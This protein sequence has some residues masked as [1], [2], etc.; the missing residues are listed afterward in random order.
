MVCTADGVV[1]TASK[2]GAVRYWSLDTGAALLCFE[3]FPLRV[4]ITA[5]AILPSEQGGRHG[6]AIAF[7][8]GQVSHAGPVASAA[9]IARHPAARRFRAACQPTRMAPSLP[10]RPHIH[11]RTI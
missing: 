5:M 10:L 7:S 2:D 1:V 6:V 3:P 9:G 4:A 8:T 11:L